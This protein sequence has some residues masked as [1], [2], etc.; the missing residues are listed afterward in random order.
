MKR[1]NIHAF[2]HLIGFV[3][4][5]GCTG[6]QV[7]LAMDTA[8]VWPAMF[9]HGV[10]IVHCFALQH[11]CVHYTVFRT[12]WLN[13]WAGRACGSII[14]LNNRFFRYEH[15]DHHTYTQRTGKDP[16]LIA[17]PNSIREYMLYLSSW[18]YWR[19]K[20]GEMGRHMIGRFNAAEKSFI[21]VE[22]RKKVVL[23]VRLMVFGYLGIIAICFSTSWSAPL[24]YWIIPLFLGEPAMRG[25]RMTEH[26]GR[27]TVADMRENTRS[28]LVSAPLRFL[29]W[30]MN[31]HAAHHYAPSVPFHALPELQR[32]I[33]KHIQVEPGGY[34]GAHRDMIRKIKMCWKSNPAKPNPNVKG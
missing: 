29:A 12:R 34:L 20:F 3:A 14:I 7:N 10:V 16:E 28:C 13:D 11:E 4:L 32:I 26:V 17:M 31:Y 30:N 2:F 5:L 1:T 19:N 9:I 21:P 25:I 15:C 24:W 27:P 23:E 22:D 18:P 6:L 8:W 33:E